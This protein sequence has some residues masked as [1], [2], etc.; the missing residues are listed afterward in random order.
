[1]KMINLEVS[2]RE[3]AYYMQGSVTDPQHHSKK[4][5]GKGK[6]GGSSRSSNGPMWCKTRLESLSEEMAEMLSY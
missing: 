4:T 1:M 3:N 6:G 5:R 2:D